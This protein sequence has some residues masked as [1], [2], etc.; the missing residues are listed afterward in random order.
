MA[1]ELIYQKH[2]SPY[3]VQ[4]DSWTIPTRFS[5]CPCS[6]AFGSL[7][8]EELRKY[9]LLFMVAWLT[10]CCGLLLLPS[11]DESITSPGN[12]SKFEVLFLLN[13]YCFH[14]IIKLKN[15][16]MNYYTM[17]T[18]CTGKRKMPGGGGFGPWG[19]YC[20]QAWSSVLLYLSPGPDSYYG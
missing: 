11:I 1:S 16:K 4:H 7:M 8:V 2:P 13:T 6:K 3:Q 20:S 9:S 18:L 10:G 19:S 15:Y 14:I 12:R 17:A 5:S